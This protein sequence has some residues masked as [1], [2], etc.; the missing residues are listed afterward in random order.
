MIQK[1]NMTFDHFIRFSLVKATLK[2]L[3]APAPAVMCELLEKQSN[4]GMRTRAGTNGDG[5]VKRCRTDL[6]QS[7]FSVE[8]ANLWNASPLELKL[9]AGNQAFHHGTETLA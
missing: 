2:C 3:N 5:G 7:A 9:Q 1:S 6:G 8:A 4:E